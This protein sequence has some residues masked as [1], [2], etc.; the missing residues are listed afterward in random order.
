MKRISAMTAVMAAALAMFAQGMR[1]QPAT[2]AQPADPSTQAQPAPQP[3]PGEE[4]AT[5]PPS[6]SGPSPATPAPEEGSASAA[7]PIGPDARA[8][9]SSTTAAPPGAETNTRLAAITPPGMSPEEACTGFKSLTE[10]A[11][12]LHAAQN[13][14]VPFADLKSKLSGGRKLGA[15]IHELKPEAN[16]REEARRAEDQAHSDVRAPQG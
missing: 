8:A 13:L 12:A 16:A 9:T 4:P 1:A 3:G 2:G 11:A 7:A 6:S 15:A 5:M 14:A 10:C